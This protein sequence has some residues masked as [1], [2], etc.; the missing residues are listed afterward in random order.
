MNYS[1]KEILFQPVLDGLPEGKETVFNF[2]FTLNLSVNPDRKYPDIRGTFSA[3][4]MKIAGYETQ[5]RVQPSLRT[6]GLEAPYVCSQSLSCTSVCYQQ[7]SLP[8]PA[9]TSET[10]FT[11][12]LPF[13]PDPLDAILTN[14]YMDKRGV[15]GLRQRPTASLQVSVFWIIKPHYIWRCLRYPVLF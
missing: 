8:L 1:G 11:H 7:G 12:H 10:S 4:W 13:R 2:G 15:M 3:S 6:K 9:P 5:P 14:F